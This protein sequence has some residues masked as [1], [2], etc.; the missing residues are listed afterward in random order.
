VVSDLDPDRLSIAVDL[1][2]EVAID[3]PD[4]AVEEVVR[5]R[6]LD[7][8]VAYEVTG[9]TAGLAAATASLPTGARLVVI[10]LHE[11]P[12]E[13]DLRHVSLAEQEVI[14][15]NAH[16]C[17]TDLPEALRMLAVGRR[18]WRVVAPLALPLDRLVDDGLLPLVEGRSERI[19]TL[20][21]PWAETIRDTVMTAGPD[22]VGLP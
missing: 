22:P 7:I 20:V 5:E 21:D 9:T 8:D 19:K 1:G 16:S 3:P 14:G 18:D 15:T 12:R 6:G 13:V 17:T 11:R 10:G 4:R 2:A